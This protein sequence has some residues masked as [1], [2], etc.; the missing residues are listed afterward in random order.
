MWPLSFH[1]LLNDGQTRVRNRGKKGEGGN[2]GAA[3][4]YM[5]DS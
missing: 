4:Q 1:R 5:Y 2:W 3:T